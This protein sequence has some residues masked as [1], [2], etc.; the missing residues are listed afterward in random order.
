MRSANRSA[1]VLV[2][3][4]WAA[5]SLGHDVFAQESES[6]VYVRQP[7]SSDFPFEPHHVS[8]HGSMMHYVDVG[9]G[10]PVLF[11]HGNPT[12]SYLWRNI[13]P[14]LEPHAR[15]VAPDLIGMGKSDTPEE[16]DY[17]FFD[18]VKYLEAFI[19]KLGLENI[20]LVVHDWGSGLGFHYASRHPDNV[21]AIAFME[22]FVQPWPSYEAMG[23][24]GAAMFKQMRT[25]DVGKELVIEQNM[26]VEQILPS[27]AH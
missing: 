20:T 17:D 19:D 5:L 6:G 11:L 8:V 1:L 16:I 13:I 15:C 23:P 26:F 7:I 18:H 3:I 14:Y 21:K 10:D 27:A 24:Q 25:P 4:A 22:A 9:E 2:C 12:W